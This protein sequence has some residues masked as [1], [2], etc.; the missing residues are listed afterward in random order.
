[1]PEVAAQIHTQ[2]L[3]DEVYTHLVKKGSLCA[4]QI[5]VDLDIPAKDVFR[6]LEQLKDEGLVELRPDR[7]ETKGYDKL[8][9]AW[10][11]PKIF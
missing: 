5:A 11:L 2:E 7:D 9:T 10:G 6:A 4:S 3:E 1:M 8:E